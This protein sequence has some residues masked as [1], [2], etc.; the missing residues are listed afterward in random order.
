MHDDRGIDH[1]EKNEGG[2]NSSDNDHD[3]WCLK[4]EEEDAPDGGEHIGAALNELSAA[5][6][7]LEVPPAQLAEGITEEA[8][9]GCEGGEEGGKEDHQ[10]PPEEDPKRPGTEGLGIDRAQLGNH[11][12]LLRKEAI[13]VKNGSAENIEEDRDE[14]VADH[15]SDGVKGHDLDPAPCSLY[16]D[17]MRFASGPSRPRSSVSSVAFFEQP[18]VVG[19]DLVS[20]HPGNSEGPHRKEDHGSGK[21]EIQ[22][23]E[24]FRSADGIACPLQSE[25]G[26]K[27]EDG[28]ETNHDEREALQ[29]SVP[30]DGNNNS[31]GECG[32]KCP[33][34]ES[35]F[36][37]SR[38]LHENEGYPAYDSADL[39]ELET[40]DE[41]PRPD[42]DVPLAEARTGQVIQGLHGSTAGVNGVF[43]KL[44]LDGDFDK[45]GEEND[46][47]TDES[48]LGSKESGGKELP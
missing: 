47:E 29:K 31:D 18:V 14:G 46:P 16:P 5:L 33:P 36:R 20:P 11:I 40:H 7:V 15:G 12:I 27:G 3:S 28:E 9:P 30:S 42:G 2:G 43:A 17:P 39:Q 32:E 34:C 48:R 8:G 26:D 44:E 37:E 4:G 45:T 6:R 1:D 10:G 35:E 38:N 25:D 23:G 24:E 41:Q 19:H 13:P 22:S 21:L